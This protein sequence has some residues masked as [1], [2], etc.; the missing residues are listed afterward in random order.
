[1]G[2]SNTER[3][4]AQIGSR[5]ATTESRIN[6]ILEPERS[7]DNLD[8]TSTQEQQ[9]VD[10]WKPPS[11]E[12]LSGPTSTRGRPGTGA[13]LL[14][15]L[16]GREPSRASNGHLCRTFQKSIFGQLRRLRF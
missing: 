13:G 8:A 15:M 2:W 10:A 6:S 4:T 7:H 5:T 12:E 9:A 11:P 16:R 1:M 3:S 14:V